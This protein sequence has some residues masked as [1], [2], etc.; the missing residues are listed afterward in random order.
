MSG[1]KDKKTIQKVAKKKRMTYAEAK[2]FVKQYKFS[3]PWKA[4]DSE[5]AKFREKADKERIENDRKRREERIKRAQESVFNRKTNEDG[6]V[7][8]SDYNKNKLSGESYTEYTKRI[9]GKSALP[10]RTSNS[11]PSRSYSSVKTKK[12][13]TS[14]APKPKPGEVI[15]VKG[16]YGTD[17]YY[18]RRDGS[19][20]KT[21]QKHI[22]NTLSSR[23]KSGAEYFVKHGKERRV[24]GSRVVQPTSPSSFSSND[25]WDPNAGL[26][27]GGSGQPTKEE[28]YANQNKRKKTTRSNASYSVD[29][30]Y[31]GPSEQ[32]INDRYNQRI[33]SINRNSNNSPGGYSSYSTNQNSSYYNASYTN[34]MQ[35][36][37]SEPVNS[38]GNSSSNSY[39]SPSSSNYG[40][41]STT[42]YTNQ[43]GTKNY[44]SRTD[45]NIG[46][47]WTQS[48]YSSSH[49][50]PSGSGSTYNSGSS[51]YHHGS[52]ASRGSTSVRQGNY[53]YHSGGGY[54]NHNTG[55]T[56]NKYGSVTSRR[57]N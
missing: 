15:P 42:K 57:R 55:T 31:T 36:I 34:N 51:S 53:S 56:Y 44:G 48:N 13:K 50:S 1:P 28:Y 37:S 21:R 12:T 40:N 38:Y 11:T 16:K 41:T 27:H 26:R 49:G 29:D 47:G 18:M 24:A 17:Y 35:H 3:K 6:T 54:T 39:S 30:Y 20:D 8:F 25:V 32:E 10:K 45:R 4:S 43:Y 5:I 52:N 9:G 46:G 2:K 19:V 22:A 7:S 14:S 33:E 23:H